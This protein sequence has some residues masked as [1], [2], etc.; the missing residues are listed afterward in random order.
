MPVVLFFYSCCS[1]R[2]LLASLL[3]LFSLFLSCNCIACILV[4]SLLI[5]CFHIMSVFMFFRR[6]SFYR[7]CCCCIV[8]HNC[9]CPT[10]P[11]KLAAPKYYFFLPAFVTRFTKIRL[12]A[13]F[14]VWIST[15]WRAQKKLFYAFPPQKTVKSSSDGKVVNRFAFGLIG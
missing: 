7:A 12:R 10:T 9:M 15:R 3:F 8:V 4:T 1:V 2:I 13:S 5:I 6:H 11:Y 14:G